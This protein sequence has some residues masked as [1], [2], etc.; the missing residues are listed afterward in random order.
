MKH[1]YL[2]LIQRH[3]SIVSM[4]GKKDLLLNRD[5]LWS[6]IISMATL[7]TELSLE[8][9]I[10]ASVSPDGFIF[11]MERTDSIDK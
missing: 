4:L 9:D 10:L 2:A 8:N 5:E 1:T 7:I 6:N 3:N 11:V